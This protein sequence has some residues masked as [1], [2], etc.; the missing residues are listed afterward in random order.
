MTAPGYEGYAP[1]F[2]DLHNH[3]GISY[4]HG[5][6]EDAYANAR[7]QLDFASV[8][9]HAH[10][11]DIPAGDPALR[12]LVA[13][14]QEG[15]RRAAELWPHIQ[16]VTE[17]V[18]E[19][20]RFVSFLSFEW[21][22]LR[23]G[24]QCV[25]YCGPRGDIIR[26]TDLEDMRR[27]L[28]ART[29]RGEAC[30]MIP[31]HI[32]YLTGRRGIRWDAFTPELSPVVEMVSMHGAAESDEGP[33][34]YLHTMGPR[35]GRSTMQH[36]L[37][38]GHLFGVIGSSD[39]HSAHPG[40]YGH[41]RLGVW[42]R[43]LTREAVWEAIVARRTF[44]LT[45]DRIVLAL[46]LDGAPMGSVLS[47]RRER[48]ISV[49]VTGGAAIDYVEVLHD[50]LPVHR[51]S[52][53]PAAP[54]PGT[55][56]KVHLE[57]GWGQRDRDVAWEVELEVVDGRLLSVEPR[58][59]GRHVVSPQARAGERYAFSACDRVADSR[60]RFRTLTWGNVTTMTPS[61]QGVCLQVA[62]E[63][64]T[65]LRARINGRDVSVSLGE[66]GE[67]ARAGYLGGFRTPAFCF[68]RAVAESEYSCRTTLT[69]RSDSRHRDWYY[70]RVCQKN[71]QWAWSSP[72]WVSAP[73]D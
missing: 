49:E 12:E 26:A 48:E 57:V 14:H 5:S 33:Y 27:H 10:W 11:P 13:Y 22:S 28:R 23:Y 52:P 18:H 21:H 37:R 25:Y 65:R 50:N 8:T 2:G 39:H 63:A 51:W 35:D 56:R 73:G 71:G 7:T 55:P 4:G 24:D 46:S 15:F 43:A 67:G 59:R 9:A 72:I 31:H 32:G 16:D 70:A 66:L 19:D 60:V 62:G 41:G 64:S 45:G 6:I 58:F 53:A 68:H 44:A 3:C 1:Y 17:A 29:A 30:F 69:H 20:G 47:A 36:G 61:T 40:S 54:R 38:R 42:A 34:P